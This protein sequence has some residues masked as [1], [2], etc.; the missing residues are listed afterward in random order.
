MS[1]KSAIVFAGASWEHRDAKS[2]DRNSITGKEFV[3][4]QHLAMYFETDL[5]SIFLHQV[6]EI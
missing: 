5:Y 4:G 2:F 3:F 1:M 6:G